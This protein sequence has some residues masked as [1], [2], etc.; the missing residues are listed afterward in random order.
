LGEEQRT[1]FRG[2]KNPYLKKKRIAIPEKKGKAP[3]H[4]GEKREEEKKKA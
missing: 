4:G 2:K 3:V 1:F